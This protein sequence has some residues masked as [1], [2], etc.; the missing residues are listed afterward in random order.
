MAQWYCTNCNAEVVQDENP[1]TC[2]TCLADGKLIVNM[3]EGLP[4]NPEDV[5]DIAR[6]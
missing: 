3:E 6:K 4:G 5:R 1:S 2:S